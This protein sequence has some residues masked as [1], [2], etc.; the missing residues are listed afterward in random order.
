M[1]VRIAFASLA[2]LSGVSLLSAAPAAIG[3]AMSSGPILLDNAKAAGNA[4]IFE[5]TTLQT[6]A[7]TSQVEL[8][9]GARVRFAA[10][11]RGKLFKDSIDLEKGSARVWNFSVNA[12]GLTVRTPG[13]ATVSLQGK[14]V[15]VAALEGEAHVFNSSGINVANLLP[16]RVLNLRSQDD[17]ATPQSV[18][19]GWVTKSNPAFRLKDDVTIV[20]VQLHGWKFQDNHR[21][22]VTGTL[23]QQPGAS[24]AV[25]QIATEKE[26]AG[27]CGNGALAAAAKAGAVGAAAGG[28]A[29]AGGV[30]A[31]GAIGAATAGGIV[32]GIST[33]AV[34]AGVATVAAVGTAVGVVETN[35]SASATGSTSQSGQLSG[36]K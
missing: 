6:Q 14:V 19:V 7:T 28:A 13:T 11:S 31:G 29:A 10:N 30:A 12:N 20:T 25:L 34:V 4:S 15:E 8:N 27:T 3:I 23:V 22:R 21:F 9:G 36:G 26:I 17:G 18:M 32:A 16:G 5:G 24:E 1:N 2:A 35:S 33:T